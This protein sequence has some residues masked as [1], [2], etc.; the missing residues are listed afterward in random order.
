LTAAGE[1]IEIERDGLHPI[2]GPSL[3]EHGNEV[4]QPVFVWPT[5]ARNHLR[6]LG[7]GWLLDEGA[8]QVQRKNPRRDR[9]GLGGETRI[10][11]SEKH[12]HQDQDESVL[13]ADQ[14]LPDCPCKAHPNDSPTGS[15]AELAEN[16]G[17]CD[18]LALRPFH[19]TQLSHAS[20]D[21]AVFG[22]VAGTS[23]G[24]G[25]RHRARTRR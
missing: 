2:V 3:A 16:F 14:K 25:A 4:A 22:G 6:Q 20:V 1:P 18:Y 15:R 8:V 12:Q 24:A 17:D 9:R 10:E 7:L 23:I 21:S 11:D 13:D 5:A 19:C